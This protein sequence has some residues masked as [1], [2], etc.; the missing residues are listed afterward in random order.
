MALQRGRCRL[1]ELLG[2]LSPAEFARRMGVNE[3]TVSRWRRGERLM[4]YESA[5]E[6]AAILGCHAEDLYYW[7]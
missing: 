3:S 7:I 1:D 4:S 6:A 5:V 2:D